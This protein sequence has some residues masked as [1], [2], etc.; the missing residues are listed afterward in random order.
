MRERLTFSK[1]AVANDGYGNPVSGEFE[2]QFTVAA[3]INFA[4]GGEDV[5]AERLG[6]RQP[7]I[8]TI[9][10][11]ENARL[12]GTDWRAVD[13]NNGA[14]IFNIRS[15]TPDEHKRQIDLLCELGVA[16]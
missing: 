10:L 16:V 8:V 13:A 7:I 14:R 2:D 5:L 6:G 1:R 15:V 11:S 3:R 12:I 9:R 4:R